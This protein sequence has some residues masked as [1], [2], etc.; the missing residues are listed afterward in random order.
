M[1]TEKIASSFA[2]PEQVEWGQFLDFTSGRPFVDVRPQC[3]GLYGG[4][5]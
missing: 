2:D 5:H 1:L 3:L 4:D